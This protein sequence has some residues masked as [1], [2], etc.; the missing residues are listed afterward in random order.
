MIPLFLIL[1]AI[2]F[3]VYV[4]LA[5]Y[6]YRL[7]MRTLADFYLAGR[8]IGRLAL[9]FSAGATGCSAWTLLGAAGYY[10][11]HGVGYLIHGISCII[12]LFSSAAF[13]FALYRAARK[14]GYETIPDMMEHYFQSRTAA[15]LAAVL[16]IVAIIPYLVNQIIGL[17]WVFLTLGGIPVEWT[18]I[19]ILAMIAV[20]AGI[21]GMRAIA[22]TDIINGS[23][24]LI[25]IGAAAFIFVPLA[26]N[27]GYFTAI[28]PEYLTTP[29]PHGIWTLPFAFSWSLGLY[30]FCGIT[31][32][33]AQKWFSAANVKALKTG[34]IG[35]AIVTFIS[36][37]GIALLIALPLKAIL[38]NIQ[39]PSD[40][41]VLVA[42][43]EIA[44][45]FAAIYGIAIWGAAISTVNTLLM[46][47]AQT[48]ARDF[49]YR[50]KIAKGET[51]SERS[52]AFM[53]RF[54]LIFA[55][56]ITAIFAYMAMLSKDFM[57][58]MIMIGS[59]GWAFA[60]PFAF[61]A[62]GMFWFPRL[63]LSKEAFYFLVF[64]FPIVSLIL[65][66]GLLGLPKNP[67]GI[68]GY[69]WATVICWPLA[70]V[71]SQVTKKPEP[72]KV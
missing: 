6:A 21:G 2:L 36:T 44:P 59:L 57:A 48:F 72:I 41:V 28:D 14:Y 62:L 23:L 65:N 7:P 12:W 15:L 34:I 5:V 35:S 67:F 25:I 17:G 22:W 8:G 55:L 51:P 40:Q 45:W 68:I 3:I 53:A 64:A 63:R 29:G 31:P 47:A 16:A 66:F 46:V 32:W 30:F 54:M 9:F 69:F 70:L 4:A 58:T 11:T 49:W 39:A 26:L 37:T 52:M 20:Y 1:V 10:Y 38:P 50:I 43:N 27:K 71:I 42:L 56:I 24:F 60:G 19:V 33:M 13:G 18:I 61:V